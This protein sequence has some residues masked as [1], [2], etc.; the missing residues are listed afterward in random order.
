MLLV[1]LL[2][3]EVMSVVRLLKV[4]AMS[5]V[6]FLKIEGMSSLIY[7]ASLSGLC[8]MYVCLNI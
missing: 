3:V 5:V 2:E 4:E 7:H 1:R 6:R 8:L